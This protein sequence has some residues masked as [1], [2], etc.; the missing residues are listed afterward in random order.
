MRYEFDPAKQAIN[1]AKHGIWFKAADDF[2]W[3]TAQFEVDGRKAYGEPRLVVTG[4]IG[5]RVHVMVVTL[6]GNAVR[7]I[8]LRKASQREVKRYVKNA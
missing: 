4:R 6:R 5:T 7:I 1:V 8:S 2:E 3:E